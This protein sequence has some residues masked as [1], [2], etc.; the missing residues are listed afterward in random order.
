M[1]GRHIGHLLNRENA[2]GIRQ[3]ATTIQKTIL[4]TVNRLSVQSKYGANT[5]EPD[6]LVH[7]TTLIG[8][9]ELPKCVNSF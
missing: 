2:V 5:L 6:K 9:L 1:E 8:R 7:A 3:K 4:S